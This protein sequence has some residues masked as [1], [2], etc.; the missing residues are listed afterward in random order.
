[1]LVRQPREAR[2]WDARVHCVQAQPN[3]VG[4]IPDVYGGGEAD[5]SH[6]FESW[7]KA[8]V[9]IG[10]RR[11]PTGRGFS[12]GGEQRPARPCACHR[13]LVVFPNV[14]KE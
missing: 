12:W 10:R 13:N 6:R 7:T 3:W 11:F 4:A 5:P 8:P 1:M 14:D 9:Q 2:Q